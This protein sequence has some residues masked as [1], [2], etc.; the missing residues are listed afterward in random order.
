MEIKKNALI[1]NKT[2]T[3]LLPCLK[4]YGDED[5]NKLKS[6]LMLGAGINDMN[7]YVK[8]KNYIYI[9]Y[10]LSP[11][12]PYLEQKNYYLDFSLFLDWIRVKNYF[13]NDYLF[14]CDTHNAHMIVIKIPDKH[15]NTFEEFIAGNYSKMYDNEAINNYFKNVNIPTN[16]EAE[17]KI[18]KNLDKTKKVLLKHLTAKETFVYTVNMDFNTDMQVNE[19]N[20]ELDYPLKLE[21]EIFNY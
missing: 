2:Y 19:F 7:Q 12:L 21:E 10:N 5:F 14:N 4:H 9:L 1:R 11:G 17:D 16:L 6:F 8:K 13:I 3:Y 20:G 15:E 18:N